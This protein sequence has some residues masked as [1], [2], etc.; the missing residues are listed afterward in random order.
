MNPLSGR[1]AIF[2]ALPRLTTP[3]R[4]RWIGDSK[5]QGPPVFRYD[6]DLTALGLLDQPGGATSQL[7]N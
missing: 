6:G 1:P 7:F 3:P 4:Y 2:A 5:E